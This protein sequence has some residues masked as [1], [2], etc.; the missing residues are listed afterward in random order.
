[1]KF[2]APPNHFPTKDEMADYLEAYAARFV[3]PVRSNS[4]VDRLYPAR[5]P[6]RREGG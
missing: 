4:R 3:L 5:R 2:P 1:M 6:F